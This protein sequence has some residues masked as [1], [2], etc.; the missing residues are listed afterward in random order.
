[1]LN[2]EIRGVVRRTDPSTLASSTFSYS[3]RDDGIF[4]D[5]RK[6]DGIATARISL[7]PPASRTSAEYKVFLEVR[8]TPQSRF[9]SLVDPVLSSGSNPTAKKPE[10]P[11]VPAFQRAGVF[12]LYVR[13]RQ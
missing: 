9:I 5:L 12:E 8:S 7:P 13:G 10:P 4:P 2:S 11:G 3:F 6:D 1:V